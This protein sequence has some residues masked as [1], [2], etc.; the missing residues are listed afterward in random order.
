MRALAVN[1]VTRPSVWPWI[2]YPLSV[3][4]LA[5]AGWQ[6]WF[7]VELAK[8][9]Q[10]A[11][12]KALAVQAEVE[13]VRQRHAHAAEPP[14]TPPAYTQDAEA[15]SRQAGFDAGRVLAAIEAAQVVG[16]KVSS[17]E[18]LPPEQTARVELEVNDPA[19]LLQY[20]EQLNAGMEG[21]PGWRL[22]RTQSATGTAAGSATIVAGLSVG[23]R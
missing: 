19:A 9:A 22:L 18:I 11:E 17:V 1:F 15:I 20:L 23:M 3:G 7:A 13:G 10:L 4:L 5:V 21:A 6:G 12:D 16:V 2:G 14:R 8:Q